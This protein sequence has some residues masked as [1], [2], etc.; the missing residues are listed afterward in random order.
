M[1]R[2][3]PEK[4]K[5]LRKRKTILKYSVTAI[6][7]AGLIRVAMVM[8]MSSVD[9]NSIM[10]SVVDR[11]TIE[12]SNGASGVVKPV[13]EEIINTPVNSRIINI[14]CHE[15]DSVDVGT[16]LLE[17][18]LKS[19][20][21]EYNNLLDEKQM[22]LYRLEQMRIKGMTED[23]NTAMQIKV[24][25]MKV[26]RMEVEL[27]N[28]KYLDSIGSGTT[29]KVKQAEYA[30]R[31]GLLEL[32][33]LKQQYMNEKRLREADMKVSRLE[34]NIFVKTLA[35]K[36]RT[37]D[38]ARIRS[39]RKA[40]LTYIINQK[41]AQ[42]AAGTQVAT[43]SDLSHFKVECE[44]SDIYAGQISIGDKAIVRTGRNR[45]TGRV[46]NIT[47]QSKNGVIAFSV[48][49]DDD[50]N[51][52]LRSGLKVDVY[53]VKSVKDNTLRIAN[54]SYYSK[55]GEYHLY[56]KSSDDRLELRK[57]RLGECSFSHVEVISGL[58]EGEEVV[59]SDMSE[60]NRKH[61][62]IR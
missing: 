42:V 33:Q 19:I 1:D 49:L 31:T 45:L 36:K 32:E 17:L 62:K 30:Y 41:G 28:E 46:S 9:K 61:I 29:D 35:E 26:E 4:I 16:P 5:R 50:D 14:L 55:P 3:I 6:V 54:S 60:Y 27:R 20:E 12:I 18:D 8:T 34:Y 24:N 43:V 48:Q 21:T 58:R 11:G 53:A 25:Q 23:S 40:I 22:K 15:G 52:L 56:V 51:S 44:I 38:D 39:P 10:T 57:V 13:S 2:E 37:L 59:I 47:P 7:I